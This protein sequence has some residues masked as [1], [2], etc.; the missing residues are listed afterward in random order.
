MTEGHL[1]RRADQRD[2]KRVTRVGASQP[3]KD[4]VPLGNGRLSLFVRGAY[5]EV[6][7]SCFTRWWCNGFT[8]KAGRQYQ[9]SQ[10]S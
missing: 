5:R 4:A 9:G 1:G 10:F 2:K 3:P 8:T 6:L 7:P